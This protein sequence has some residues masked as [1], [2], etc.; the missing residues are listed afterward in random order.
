MIERHLRR[1]GGV[2][3]AD[4]AQE[5]TP[6][7]PLS[8][9]RH[10]GRAVDNMLLAAFQTRLQGKPLR[11]ESRYD[12]GAMHRVQG[13]GRAESCLTHQAGRQPDHRGNFPGFSTL[14]GDCRYGVLEEHAGYL[15]WLE[16]G[17]FAV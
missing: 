12:R 13:S 14:S 1:H 4:A 10:E 16:L 6:R 7:L 15:S 9:P 8:G 17:D 5:Q 3:H 2:D 11:L